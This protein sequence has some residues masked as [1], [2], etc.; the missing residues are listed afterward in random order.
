MKIKKLLFLVLYLIL[1][2]GFIQTYLIKS[3]YLP[4]LSDVILFYI[5]FSNK[6]NI[7]DVSRAVGSWVVRL[8]AILLVGSTAISI[9]N[10]MPTIT[11][12][13]GLRMVVRY[14][15]LFML[16]YKYF[17]KTDVDKFKR[18]LIRFFWIN[19]LIVAYQFFIEKKVADFIGGIFLNNGE[20]FVFNLYCTLL[21]SKEYFI[22]HLSKFRF[23]FLLVVEMFVAMVAEIKVMYFTIPL[24]VYAVFI[25]T[26]KF[27]IKHIVVLVCAFFFLVPCMKM[28]M[29]LMYGEEYVNKTFDME[30]I[31]EE[32]SH[33][34][35]LSEEA[36]DFSFNRSTCVEMASTLILNDPIHLLFGYGVGSG[37][38][39]EK[40]G[41]WI[42][43]T[44]SEITSYNWF[45]SS[46]LLI[47]YGWVGY[48][49]WILIIFLLAHRFYCLYLKNDD[50]VVKYWSSLGLIS[51]SFTYILAWYNNM[52][53]YNAYFIYLF[54]AVCFVGIRERQK[55]LKNN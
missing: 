49:I 43:A 27:S 38:T 22:G 31:Q 23:I 50:Q 25:F 48:I 13:W 1:L 12:I 35:N 46:W 34:Y 51:V 9:M 42:S 8:F 4:L 40:F 16:V 14:L 53:Y 3:E 33:A 21:L 2:N 54:W 37:N 32:T 18:I 10:V 47:E 28:A 45:T 44:Y 19:T 26:K 6:N 15:L 5:A 30:F 55:E 11:I 41:T 52:P 7:L 20:L 29:S 17:I 24:A 39:S 36:A